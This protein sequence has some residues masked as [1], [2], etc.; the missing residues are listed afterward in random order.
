MGIS[1]AQAVANAR[2]SI[3]SR[4]MPQGMCLNFVWRMFGSLNSTGYAQGTLQSAMTAWNGSK[5]KYGPD[6][7]VPIG[8]P[9]YF[10]VS[11]TRTDKNKYAGDV[12]I[13][14]GDGILACTDA[15]GA[16]TGYM[17]IA[18]RAKQTQRPYI[19]WTGDFG[20]RSIDFGV[21][22]AP[23]DD[24]QTAVIPTNPQ[25]DTLHFI[26][27]TAGAG[28][29]YANGRFISLDKAEHMDL[30]RRVATDTRTQ[31]TPGE[32]DVMNSYLERAYKASAREFWDY[33]IPG[34]NGSQTAH[35]R[36]A[37]IDEKANTLT[38]KERK[39]VVDAVVAGLA[40]GIKVDAEA[41]V[42]VPAIAEAV[43]ERLFAGRLQQ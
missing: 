27:S 24:G 36:L 31:F 2:A 42:D 35:A 25:E 3:V 23:T 37:G 21:T 39:L 26:T 30:F 16:N 7:P 22:V 18:A 6:V 32:I 38:E 1:A 34:Y 43:A 8:A 15:S 5:E 33:G 40:A 29:V 17:T 13:H 4:Q 11:P 14:V 19:G 41:T 9:V 20:G 28:Y 12:T 10:G